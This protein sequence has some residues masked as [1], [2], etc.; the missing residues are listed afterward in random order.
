MFLSAGFEQILTPK[1]LMKCVKN[2]A[3]VWRGVGLELGLELEDINIIA[4]NNPNLC[5]EACKDMLL[6][7]HRRNF[8]LTLKML[9]RAVENY[10]ATSGRHLHGIICIDNV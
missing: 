4:A 6:K 1:A 8:N 10:K 9:K 7:C 5:E 3:P 2:I